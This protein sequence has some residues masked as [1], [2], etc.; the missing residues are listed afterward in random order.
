MKQ[1]EEFEGAL[2]TLFIFCGGPGT[3]G[4]QGTPSA[5]SSVLPVVAH[6]LLGDIQSR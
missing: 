1:A 4:M 5:F 6:H 3:Q 2:E